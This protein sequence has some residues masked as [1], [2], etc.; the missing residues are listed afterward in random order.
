MDD[1]IQPRT[2]GQVLSKLRADA[3]V[4]QAALAQNLTVSPARVSRIE[5]GEVELTNDE[6]AEYLRVLGTERATEFGHYLQQAWNHLQRPDFEHPDLLPIRCAEETLQRISELRTPELTSAFAKQLDLFEDRIRQHASYLLP[7]HHSIAFLGSIGVGKSTAIC[8]LTGLRLHG[9]EQLNQQMALEVGGGGTT[10]CEVR[11]RRG[12]RWGL[13]I[14]PRPDD[15]IRADVTD[16]CEYLLRATSSDT[17]ET[18]ESNIGVPRE[19]ERVIR[20]MSRLT[21]ISKKDDGRKRLRIDPAKE[22]AS[23]FS[24]VPSLAVE[25]LTRMDLPRR[26]TRVLW[27][28]DGSSQPPMEWLQAEFAKINNG[29]NPEVTIPDLIEVSMPGAVFAHPHLQI[30]V[31]DTKGIDQTVQREDLERHFDDARTLTVLC[32]AFLDAP[33]QAVQTLLERAISSGVS[34]VAGTTL[35]LVL[36]R[37]GESAAMKDDSGNAV[38][39][40]HEGYDF[41]RDQ[42]DLALRRITPAE[43]SVEFFNAK[44]DDLTPVRDSLLRALEHMRRE[45]REQIELLARQVDSL[46]ANREREEAAAT[47]QEALR[48]V[49]AWLQ[50]N[51]EGREPT[52]AVQRSLI[53]A[54]STVHPASV[55]ASVRRHGS[56]QNLDYYYQ[57]GFEAKR[58]A[59]QYTKSRVDELGVIV[60]NLLHIEDLA[61]A[62]GI[63]SE[64][65]AKANDFVESLLRKAQLTGQTLYEDALRSDVSFWQQSAEQWGVGSGYRE[66]VANVS[67]LWFSVPEQQIRLRVVLDFVQTAW[68]DLIEKLDGLMKAVTDDRE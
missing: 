5:S 55:R 1:C 3:G 60:N 37:P 51:R 2:T 54:I 38:Q 7:V 50:Q 47:L 44:Y 14:S 42:V 56:W 24:E 25:I 33:E 62:H 64:L 35:V 17:S 53:T 27:Y 13:S 21:V 8:T 11:I 32:S 6:T 30:E 67:D 12:P 49:R 40:E 18:S 65:L 46:I 66:R 39:D 57:L 28:P 20:N 22:L 9:P 61:P 58:I 41:K 26:Q 36:A 52:G 29:R 63:L 16:F 10:V 45:R 15:A 34:R 59:A 48:P 68:H 43:L 31:I 4:T 19:T 23:S